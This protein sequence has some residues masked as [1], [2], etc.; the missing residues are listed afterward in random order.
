M[1]NEK[2][3]GA[4][5]NQIREVTRDHIDWIKSQLLKPNNFMIARGREVF[6]DVPNSNLKNI[7]TIPNKN[8]PKYKEAWARVYNLAV[9]YLEGSL[10]YAYMSGRLDYRA[11]KWPDFDENSANYARN[12]EAI[13]DEFKI[14]E[15]KRV[16]KEEQLKVTKSSVMLSPVSVK[17]IENFYKEDNDLKSNQNDIVKD[18]QEEE[19]IESAEKP[20]SINEFVFQKILDG[21]KLTK[22]DFRNLHEIGANLVILP[23]QDVDNIKAEKLFLDN[24]R[25]CIDEGIKAGVMIY[26]RATDEK[27][28]GYE[29]K[30]IFKLLDQ[31]NGMNSR[32]IIYEVNDEFVLQNKD[33]EMKLLSFINAYTLVSEG[34]SKEGYIPLISM[35][36][37]SKNILNDIYNRYNLESKY[38][39]I[40]Q[41][42]VRELEDLNKNDSTI[43][44]DPQYDYDMITLRNPKY[45]SAELIKSAL[46]NEKNMSLAKSV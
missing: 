24:M 21:D 1:I 25:F 39:I 4:L 34:L 17:P 36:L 38:E 13:L 46:D 7:V 43:L 6:I 32:C 5:I 14:V 23:C 22:K 15:A 11:I 19:K 27:E 33:S 18:E 45:N 28:A 37:T 40:Y 9:D 29:L 30:K 2:D 35:N 42:L 12:L 44:M 10:S 3:M 20:K 31:C 26:G 8:D 41:V 16:E